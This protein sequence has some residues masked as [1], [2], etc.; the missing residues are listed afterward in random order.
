M[1]AEV[2]VTDGPPMIRSENARLSGWVYVD[3]RGTDLF[4]AVKAMQA[5]VAK[6][7]ESAAG[8]LDCAGRASSNSME[9]A[10]AKLQTVI[11][12]TLVVIFSC[13]TWP[14]GRLLKRCC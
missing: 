8:L 6:R 11:P 4:T 9:R 7:G 12:L 13:C 1:S 5:S 10:T 3:V 2:K 14:F